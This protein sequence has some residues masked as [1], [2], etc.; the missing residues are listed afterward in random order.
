MARLF[1]DRDVPTN[2]RDIPTS[3]LVGAPLLIAGTA[4]TIALYR[5]SDAARAS[6]A[7]RRG[8]RRVRDVMTQH[9]TCCRPDTSLREVAE[10]MVACD[11]GE[12]PVCDDA[13]KPIGVVT[14]RDIVCRLLAKGHDPLHATP[15]DCMSRPVITCMPETRIDEC[16]RLMQRHQIRRV[17]IV[18]RNGTLVG[19]VAQADLARRSP[20]P[21]AAEMLEDVSEPNVFASAVGGR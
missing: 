16:A 9:P 20:H 12:I 1:G 10:M 15:R 14:D 7:R 21:V 19:M 3:L 13:R 2:L 8:Q 5:R 11:C 4:A 6:Q 18:D 17:P